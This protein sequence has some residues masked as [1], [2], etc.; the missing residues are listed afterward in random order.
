[1]GLVR[2]GG[3]TRKEPKRTYKKIMFYLIAMTLPWAE[4]MLIRALISFTQAQYLWLN[5]MLILRNY[6]K[7]TW[8]KIPYFEMFP[9]QVLALAAHLYLFFHFNWTAI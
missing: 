4:R 1:M 5:F 9:E 6:R 7:K 2:S 8:I 3:R